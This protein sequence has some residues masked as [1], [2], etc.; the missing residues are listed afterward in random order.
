MFL[1]LSVFQVNA[2]VKIGLPVGTAQSSSVLDLSNTGTGG[3]TKGLI[4]PSVTNTA[5]IAT[6]YN[7]MIVYDLSST[8]TKAY[9][10][11]AWTGCL[12]QP[13]TPAVAVNCSASAI[14][15]LYTTNTALTVSNTI[16]MV[17][18]NN[19]FSAVTITPSTS[20]IVFSGTAA[21]GITVS[22]VSPASVSPGAGGGTSTITYTL[23]GT[24][25]TAGSFTATWTK[26]SLSCTKT[27]NVC[28]AISAITVTNTTTP[29]TLPIPV[30]TGNTINFT[31]AGG[32]PNTGLSWTMTS[33]PSS[34][35]FSNTASG[36]GT[37]AQA[38]LVGGAEGTVTITFTATNACG[39]TVTGTQTVGMGDAIRAGLSTN[40]LVYDAATT[41]T[42]IQVTAA[43]YSNLSTTVTGS[44]VKG[45]PNSQFTGT[46][47]AYPANYTTSYNFNADLAVPASNYVFALSYYSTATIANIVLKT[48][49]AVTTGYNQYS[50]MIS[51]SGLPT[52][53]SNRVFFVLK[54]PSTQTASAASNLAL[55]DA[56][57]SSFG[58]I[59][60]GSGVQRYSAN[61]NVSSP[62]SLATDSYIPM[63]VLSVATQQW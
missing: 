61:G 42:W 13:A 12:S 48:S 29:S 52:S 56:T 30:V 19:S 8:C 11:G 25:T 24:P 32:T 1:V 55:Y 2:Q 46:T 31:A 18:T 36:T 35:I 47:A 6:P 60:P 44:T 16:T 54:R 51:A 3:L 41:N 34:G 23:N 39:S 62:S 14:N 17:L 37:T 22:S 43:E 9:E 27:S 57:Y 58:Y 63:Q 4:I 7:G 59:S 21:P 45:T 33:S 50:T 10:N 20:D 53:G 15:G 49:T 40:A 26:L 5:S 28:T 38:V